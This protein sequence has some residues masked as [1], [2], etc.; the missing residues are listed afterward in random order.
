MTSGGLNIKYYEDYRQAARMISEKT[1]IPVSRSESSLVSFTPYVDNNC[2]AACR[3]CSERLTK[4]GQTSRCVGICRDY[5]QRLEAALSRLQGKQVF[6]SV[7]GKE[8]TESPG[9]LK[10]ICRAACKAKAQGLSVSEA[11]LYTN[12]SGFCKYGE[13]LEKT[14]CALPLSRIEFSR[15]HFDENVN[16]SIM[17]FR[18]G[19]EIKSNRALAC[20]V[21][22]LSE[23]FPMK[24][25]CVLQKTGVADID[26]VQRY[27]EFARSLGV[28]DVVFR[29]LAVFDG[30]V[31][32]GNT[33]D[34]II[35]ER[36]EIWELL[37]YL[38]QS[39]F[40]LSGI[41]EGYYYFSFSCNYRDMRVSFEMSDYEEMERQHAGSILHKLILYPDGMLCRSWNKKGIV[42]DDDG[43]LF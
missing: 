36:V 37:P 2:S 5:E 8:P 13:E 35:S 34:Y 23:S 12:L 31:D 15:H 6:L 9:Q 40:E 22:K 19:E 17:Q 20:V 21:R 41:R 11:V 7:S 25:V 28:R 39:P 14:L 42:E 33:A 3:F 16:Q 4:N 32:K 43:K 27:V 30:S 26:G 18:P 29:E 10:T 24:A 38:L 1:G